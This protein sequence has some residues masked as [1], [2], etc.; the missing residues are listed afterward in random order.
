MPGVIDVLSMVG[1][2]IMGPQRLERVPEPSDIT[3]AADNVLQ[4]DQVM[5]TKLVL[6]YALG[7]HVLH[8]ARPDGRQ[9][10]AVDL[11]C[12]PGHYTICLAQYFGYQS[13]RGIDLSFPMVTTAT[14]NAEQS[15]LGERIR[16]EVGDVTHL[17]TV[18]DQSVDLASFTDASHHLPDLEAVRRTMKEMDRVTRDEGLVMIMDVARLRTARLTERFVDTLGK[19]YKERGLKAFLGDFHNSMYAAWTPGELFSAIPTDSA[20]TWCHLVPRG[21]PSVQVILGLPVGRTK[22]FVRRGYATN[23]H[24]LIRD[25]YPRWCEQVRREW[26]DETVFDWKV[27]R[28][29]VSLARKRFVRPGR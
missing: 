9:A 2:Q 10:E 17:C 19:D 15:D 21:L 14:K 22:P 3:D 20:R 11:A 13:I 27:L 16:F 6:A 1:C 7:L 18:S 5:H 23:A 24:P 29:M 26:A 8:R 25:W 4:Y 12:G 28:T